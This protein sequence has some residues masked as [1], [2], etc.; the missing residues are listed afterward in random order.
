MQNE[1][2]K[3]AYRLTDVPCKR[4]GCDR[5]VWNNR[6]ICFRCGGSGFESVAFE[7]PLTAN[8]AASLAEYAAGIAAREAR[9]AARKARR[10]ARA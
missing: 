5:G 2:T 1:L 8:E 3:T 4:R 10:A 6:G 9:E 7:R